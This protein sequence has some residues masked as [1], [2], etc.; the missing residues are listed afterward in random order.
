MEETSENVWGPTGTSGDT[1]RQT[2]LAE[3]DTQAVT[4][5]KSVILEFSL[6]GQG[7]RAFPKTGKGC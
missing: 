1:G 2:M 7:T 6:Q 5:D 4:D 3:E